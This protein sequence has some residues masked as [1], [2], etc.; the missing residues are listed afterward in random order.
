MPIEISAPPRP[1]DRCSYREIM[2][3]VV[4]ADGLWLKVSLDEVAPNQP[5]A[6]KQTR[7]W[8]AAATRGI[9]VQT[10]IQR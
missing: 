7:L 9:K 6:V 10:T 1:V 5:F 3:R 2:E 4:E 8:Q